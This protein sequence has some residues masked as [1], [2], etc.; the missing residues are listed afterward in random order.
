MKGIIEQRNSLKLMQFGTIFIKA[1]CALKA[2]IAVLGN[3]EF[4]LNERE[5]YL[6]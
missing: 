4:T 2:K 5:I 6:N 3:I 1:K